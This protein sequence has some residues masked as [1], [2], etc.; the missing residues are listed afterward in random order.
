MEQQAVSNAESS[1]AEMKPHNSE[2]RSSIKVF[3]PLLAVEEP[4]YIP[5]DFGGSRR[6]SPHY[7]SG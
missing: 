2:L 6:T 4:S 1:T 3:Q 7:A 5:P